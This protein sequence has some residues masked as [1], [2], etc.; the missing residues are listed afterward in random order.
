[1]PFVYGLVPGVTQTTSGTPSTETTGMQL[2]PL[3][4]TATRTLRF[5][6]FYIHGKGAGL[7]AISGISFRVKMMSAFSS[8][9]TTVNPTARDSGVSAQAPD[10]WIGRRDGTTDGA[11]TSTTLV[12]GCGAAGASGWF[13]PGPAS[14]IVKQ[15][16][17]GEGLEIRVASGLASMN[18]EESAEFSI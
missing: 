5:I 16:V 14:D 1:M 3:A 11:V 15:Y 4:V 9:G 7:T 2:I 13:S 10:A 8:G 18:Y 12:I 6:G 17:G